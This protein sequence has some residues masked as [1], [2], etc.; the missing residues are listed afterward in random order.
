MERVKTM[1]ED[2][3]LDYGYHKTTS[4]LQLAGFYINHKKV[5]RLMKSA[6]L[7]KEKHEK[8]SKV[9]VK[10]RKV[11]PKRPLEVLEMDIK[12]VWV[13][14]YKR[15]AYVLTVI[16][17]F[18]RVV[19]HWTVAYFIRKE[20]VKRAWE[21]IIVHHLQPNNCLESGVHIE[22]RNDND[23]RFS[24]R[25]IQKFFKENHLNQVFTHPYTPQENGHIESFHAILAKKLKPYH[26][27]KM[28]ELETLLTIFYDKYNN[29]RLHA[30]VCNLPPNIFLECWNKNLIDQN[31]DEKRRKITFKLRIPYQQISANTSWKCSSLQSLAIP[32]SW[33][34]EVNFTNNEMISA[35][36][37][38]QT[39]V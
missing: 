25:M 37:F 36:T 11:F 4:A 30:S 14:E 27:W 33:G 34:D 29:E 12:F 10:Y 15:H 2:E 6:H 9:H 23:S 21:H 22:V 7:L 32:P 17:T 24:A 38:L 28:E 13:E 20:D 19:L 16:D 39:S 8:P 5:Y 31:E 3:D 1:R 35:E 18:T 26:F